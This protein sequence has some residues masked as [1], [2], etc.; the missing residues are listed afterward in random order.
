MIRVL[1]GSDARQFIASRHR[2]EADVDEVVKPIIEDVRLRGDAALTEWSTRLDA[3]EGRPL[4][5]SPEELSSAEASGEFLEALSVAERNVRKFAEFQMPEEKE[6]TIARGVVAG[7]IVRPLETVGAY[8]P[9]GVYP[10]PSTLVMTVVPAQVAGVK[11]ICVANPRP[12]PETLAAAR[13]LGVSEFFRV[14]GAQA[15]AAFAFGTETIP[16]VDRVVGPGNKYV[17]AA[18]RLL[19]GEVGIDSV[20]GPSEVVIVANEG[21][22]EWIA[23]DMLAQA[24]HD[25]SASSI[26]VTSS[27]ELV[28]AV[29]ESLER[30]LTALKTAAVARRSLEERGAI[31]MAESISQAMDWVNLLAPEH[32]CLHE[33]SLVSQVQNAGSIFLGPLSTESLGDYASGPNHV[34]PTGGHARVRGGLSVLDFVKVITYQRIDREGLEGLAPAVTTLARAEGLEGHARAVEVRL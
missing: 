26:F 2:F 11:R 14:G 3:L 24:E 16:K 10:L 15:I 6:T 22:A 20:A 28:S 30:Q 8:I 9:G 33:P 7:Q 21:N 34:L 25:V 19:A 23:A 12:V 13:V 27:R 32:L 5:V 29:G 31:L 17:A 1:S 18:K 4:A